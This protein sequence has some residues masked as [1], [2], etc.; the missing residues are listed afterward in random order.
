MEVSDSCAIPALTKATQ[1][2]VQGSPVAPPAPQ[3]PDALQTC[4][5][6]AIPVLTHPTPQPGLPGPPPPCL[7]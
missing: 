5:Y 3:G 1:L 4:S 2:L 7:L 6:I